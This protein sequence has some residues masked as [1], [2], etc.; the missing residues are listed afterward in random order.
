M[1]GAVN[2]LRYILG[3]YPEIHPNIYLINELLACV[4]AGPSDPK[5]Y[6]LHGTEHNIISEGSPNE[7]PGLIMEQ[8]SKIL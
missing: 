2:Q 7:F 5:L 8:K 6:D 1:G 3:P 4:G